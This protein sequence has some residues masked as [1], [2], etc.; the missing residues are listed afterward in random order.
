MLCYIIYEA[1][2]T[3]FSLTQEPSC[4]TFQ[5][6]LTLYKMKI[7]QSIMMIEI[8]LSSRPILPTKCREPLSLGWPIPVLEIQISLGLCNSTSCPRANACRI[9]KADHICKH[10]AT[11]SWEWASSASRTRK[12]PHAFI[13]PPPARAKSKKILN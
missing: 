10:Q 5:L 12:A 1:R 2:H 6:Q 7:A 11:C 4:P 13:H 8:F 3:R 9:C